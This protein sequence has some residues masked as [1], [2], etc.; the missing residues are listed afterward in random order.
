MDKM[1]A[2]VIDHNA[3]GHVALREVEA[4][5]PAANEALVKV[6][7]V[8]LN[9]GEVRMAQSREPGARIADRVLFDQRLFVVTLVLVVFSHRHSPVPP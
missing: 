6:A 2:A 1:R 4:S 3:P 9:L 7:A 8:S 5:A